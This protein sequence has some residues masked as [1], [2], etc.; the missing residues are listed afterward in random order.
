MSLMYHTKWGNAMPGPKGIHLDW[1]VCDGDTGMALSGK[2]VVVI[3]CTW[4]REIGIRH[5]DQGFS[6]GHQDM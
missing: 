2:C 5:F 6:S 1:S 3:E 4:D